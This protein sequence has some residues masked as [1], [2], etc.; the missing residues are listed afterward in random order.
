MMHN[1]R[2][3]HIS[4]LNVEVENYVTEKFLQYDFTYV[5]FKFSLKAK[6]NRLHKYIDISGKLIK[7]RENE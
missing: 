1:C 6:R 4:E 2:H 3:E 7:K 5:K